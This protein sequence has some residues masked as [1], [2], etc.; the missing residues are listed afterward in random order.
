[1]PCFAPGAGAGTLPV[2]LVLPVLPGSRAGLEC[3]SGLAHLPATSPELRACV[4][5]VLRFHLRDLPT[6]IS[7]F[8][9]VFEEATPP[10]HTRTPLLLAASVKPDSLFR[11]GWCPEVEFANK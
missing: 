4:R 5:V 11:R 1:M 8:A 6:E 10:Q 2:N 7:Y 3:C 9:S